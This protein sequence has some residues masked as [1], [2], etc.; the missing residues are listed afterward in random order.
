M[1]K[2]L[3]T[4]NKPLAQLCRRMHES[5]VINMKTAIPPKLIILKQNNLANN[6]KLLLKLKY[7]HFH[8]TTKQPND[9]FM[10]NDCR[11]VKIVSLGYYCEH[12]DDMQLS[13]IHWLQKKPI[14]EYPTNSGD[15][16]M[17]QLRRKPSKDIVLFQLKDI[18]F[19]MIQMQLSS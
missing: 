3:R 5:N 17:W 6:H 11:I 2:F 7:R 19:K 12:E 1:R 18:K 10:L 14:F 8:I 16:F 4:A 15:L 9:L 13:G